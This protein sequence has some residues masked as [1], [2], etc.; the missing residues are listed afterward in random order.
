MGANARVLN[1]ANGAGH[2]LVEGE[3][4]KAVSADD[5]QPG[6]SVKVTGVDGLTV[7]VKSSNRR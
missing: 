5:L 3:R 7:R 1:W 2:V 6:D 4:W